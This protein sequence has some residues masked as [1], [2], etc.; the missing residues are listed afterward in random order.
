MTDER[1]GLETEEADAERTERKGVA[2][3]KMRS[4]AG[5]KKQMNSSA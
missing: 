2:G 3:I 1:L 4:E 5:F